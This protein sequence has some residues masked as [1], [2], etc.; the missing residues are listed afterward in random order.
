MNTLIRWRGFNFEG[1]KG[2][3]TMSKLLK[4][5]N[6]LTIK[7]TAAHLSI[8]SGEEITEADVLRLALDGKL[9]ASL[10]L[11]KHTTA[12][13]AEMIHP[14]P[15]MEQFNLAHGGKPFGEN[16]ILSVKSDEIIYINGIFDL[17][18]IGE[19][20]LT[21]EA[22]YYRLLNEQ[23]FELPVGGD[24]L[25]EQDGQ[26]FIFQQVFQ[27]HATGMRNDRFAEIGGSD[28]IHKF[29]AMNDYYDAPLPEDG[30]LIIRTEA[31]RKFEKII[32]DEPASAEKPLVETERSTLLTII[33][34]LCDYS[35][36]KYQ[37]RGVA[38]QIAKMT[39]EI[40]AAISDDAVRKAI[41]KIP[42]ALE[43]RK[44]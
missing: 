19:E 13:Y 30:M 43:T 29:I 5:K 36:I 20:R 39:E 44:K 2:N 37:D 4:L 25:V 28:E 11:P 42:N 26:L 21:I 38:V 23:P 32:T 18:M 16:K 22:E 40:G 15:E 27:Q 7:E 31:L 8:I 17:P 34:G 9:T 10:H 14:T 24:Y 35:D 33:A 3:H 1:R 6:W 12:K 41:A